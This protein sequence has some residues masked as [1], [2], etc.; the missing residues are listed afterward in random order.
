MSFA[1][2]IP[3]Y[4]I[5]KLISISNKVVTKNRFTGEPFGNV[6]FMT[7][8]P[9]K[10]IV[11]DMTVEAGSTRYLLNYELKSRKDYVPEFHVGD[12]LEIRME[13]GR[14]TMFIKRPDGKELET[15]ISSLNHLPQ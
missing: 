6:H 7:S 10:V 12:L 14:E 9:Y 3:T 2:E 5:A 11:Y 13:E 4:K 15:R 8:T 1:K